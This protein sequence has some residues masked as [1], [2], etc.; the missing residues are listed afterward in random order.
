MQTTVVKQIMKVSLEPTLLKFLLM[1]I[2]NCEIDM[3]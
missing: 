1:F 2:V 3:Q